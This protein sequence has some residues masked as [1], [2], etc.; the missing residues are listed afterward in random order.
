[1]SDRLKVDML[2]IHIQNKSIDQLLEMQR[3]VVSKLPLLS[4]LELEE[5]LWHYNEFAMFLG[6]NTRSARKPII[7][8]TLCDMIDAALVIKRESSL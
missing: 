6:G 7:I 8:Y 2:K 3:F 4:V 1:M 5:L